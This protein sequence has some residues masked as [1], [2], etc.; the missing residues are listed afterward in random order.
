LIYRYQEPIMRVGMIV[1]PSDAWKLVLAIALGAAILTAAY[2]AAPKRTVPPGDLRRLVLCALGL[3]AVGG[4]ASFSGH[5]TLAAAVYAVGI[6]MCAFALWLSRATDAG[7]DPPRGS[8]EPS[9]GPPPEPDG[10]PEFDFAAFEREFRAYAR[11][12]RDPAVH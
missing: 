3:Y 8:E 11:R 1:P 2:A 7:E 6:G 12:A 10:Q 4:V 9:E 5:S